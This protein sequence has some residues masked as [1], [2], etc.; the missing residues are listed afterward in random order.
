MQIKYKKTSPYQDVKNFNTE[1]TAC[2]REIFC[3]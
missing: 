1:K 2:L 3:F